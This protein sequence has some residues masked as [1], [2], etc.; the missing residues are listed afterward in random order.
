VRSVAEL[1]MIAG[2]TGILPSDAGLAKMAR[3][4]GQPGT[5]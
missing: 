2:R 3:T 4:N 5:H 1:V